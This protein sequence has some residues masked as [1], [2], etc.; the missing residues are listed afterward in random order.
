M[1]EI[2]LTASDGHTLTAHRADPDHDP[3]G[4]IVV[5]QEIF[6]VNEHI[7]AITD[8]F[9]ASGFLAIAPALFDRVER[10]VELAY[11][12]EGLDKGRGIAWG[13]LSIEQ[14]LTDL[15][16]ATDALAAEL[17]GANRVGAVG[18]CYGGMLAAALVSRAPDHLAAAVAYYPSQAAQVLT[19]DIVQRPLLIHLGKEDQGVTPADGDTLAARW[20]DAIVHRYDGAGHGFNCDLRAGFHA[21]ASALAWERTIAFLGDRL[22]GQPSGGAVQ[23]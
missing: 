6:G 19:E 7:R 14:A 22:G 18:F 11:D 16:A 23:S 4:G 20:P 9:A 5:I 12:A 21:E 13:Q 1:A 2:E 10:G 3:I 17:G 15:S 8:R